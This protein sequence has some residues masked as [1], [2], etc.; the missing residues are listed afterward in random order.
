MSVTEPTL[1]SGFFVWVGARLSRV[2]YLIKIVLT[3][4]GLVEKVNTGI[5]RIIS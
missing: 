1:I 4:S 3:K 2:R 5:Y